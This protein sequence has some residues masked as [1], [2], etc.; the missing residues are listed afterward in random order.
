M[1][2]HDRS[3]VQ[4]GAMMARGENDE[5]IGFQAFRIQKGA[6]KGGGVRTMVGPVRETVEEAD[7]DARK[8][9]DAERAA[10]PEAVSPARACG[11][12]KGSW[13]CE[14]PVTAYIADR[15]ADGWACYACEEHAETMIEAGW[16]K[17]D[18]VGS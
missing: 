1:G 10:T 11:F 7:A 8:A 18:A 17:L 9:A 5:A 4:W 2:E 3:P 14:Q 6:T 12:K 16:T 13:P 15:I